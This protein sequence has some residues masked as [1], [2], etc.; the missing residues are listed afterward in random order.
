MMEFW[1]FWRSNRLL[2]LASKFVT[3]FRTTFIFG[4]SQY[5]LS[6]KSYGRLKL[7][8]PKFLKP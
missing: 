5:E 6:I 7:F 2:Q 4:A 3:P 8:R 1:N